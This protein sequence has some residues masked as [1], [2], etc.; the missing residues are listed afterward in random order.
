MLHTLPIVVKI[1]I[2]QNGTHYNQHMRLEQ[3]MKL[4]DDFDTTES[5]YDYAYL[6]QPES[7]ADYGLRHWSKNTPSYLSIGR[8]CTT[9]DQTKLTEL[10][11]TR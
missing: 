5:E 8:R 7:Y 6:E 2:H 4:I 10:S 11:L 1:V 9:V 3:A